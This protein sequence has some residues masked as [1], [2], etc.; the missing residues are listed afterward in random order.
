MK[1]IEL[2]TA[3]GVI[4]LLPEY[5][6][7]VLLEEGVPDREAIALLWK[8]ACNEKTIHLP[9]GGELRVSPPSHPKA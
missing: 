9:S 5:A 8:L 2:E 1:T 7:D 4:E 3:S 6:F